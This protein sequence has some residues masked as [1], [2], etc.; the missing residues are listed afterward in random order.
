MLVLFDGF[1]YQHWIPAA[2]IL[3]ILLHAHRI[4][5][6]VAVLIDNPPESRGLDLEYNPTFV[7]FLADELLPWLRGRWNVTHD[8]Q[9][10]II[11]GYSMGGA[12]AAFA[13][14]RRPDLFG[15]VLSQSGS[16]LGGA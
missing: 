16:F 10:T 15:D 8:P 5:P 9:K 12:A 13:A 14:M 3:D 11:G 2:T 7:N 1:S 4:P 6:I